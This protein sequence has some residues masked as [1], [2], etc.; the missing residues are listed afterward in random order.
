MKEIGE[1]QELDTFIAHDS[2]ETVPKDYSFI[3]V[4]FVFGVKYDGRGKARM[5]AREHL[6]N[7][8]TSEVYSGVVSIKN[9]MMILF[10]AYLN[11]MEVIA[12]DV[13]NAFLHFKIREKLYTKGGKGAGSLEDK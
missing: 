1:A 13:Y 11:D 5:V 9:V 3:P 4:Q 10:L 2:K 6:T 7:P 8:D 12:A